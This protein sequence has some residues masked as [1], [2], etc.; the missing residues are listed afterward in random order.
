MEIIIFLFAKGSRQNIPRFNK[1]L[2]AKR[3]N[4][5]LCTHFY[6]P[7]SH[8]FIAE[9]KD[10][11][12]CLSNSL[13]I[14]LEVDENFIPK[15][16]NIRYTSANQLEIN[17]YIPESAQR[18]EIQINCSKS[19]TGKS[20]R[21][22]NFLTSVEIEISENFK[23]GSQLIKWYLDQTKKIYGYFLA[24]RTLKSDYYNFPQ[25]IM[26]FNLEIFLH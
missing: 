20:H 6:E 12:G 18:Q 14:S 15:F 19:E 23:N 5:T 24:N 2:N 13:Q 17:V 8:Q 1:I 11:E 7:K 4:E 3:F 25:F 26:Q 16:T 10:Q 9:T 21:L 22:K